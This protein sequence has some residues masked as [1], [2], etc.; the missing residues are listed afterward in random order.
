M[1]RALTALA[2]S[3]FLAVIA[4][5]ALAGGG[6]GNWGSQNVSV[7]DRGGDHVAQG[8]QSHPVPTQTASTDEKAE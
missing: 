1:K 4:G 7:P 5:P 2:A 6:C 8:E 3:G